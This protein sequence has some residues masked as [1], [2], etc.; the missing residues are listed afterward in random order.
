M[1]T[2]ETQSVD[3]PDG[4]DL[5]LFGRATK[6]ISAVLVGEIEEADIILLGEERATPAQEIKSLKA[7]HHQL[8]RLLAEGTEPGQAAVIAGYTLS[9]V[10]VLQA[11]HAFNELVIFYRNQVT[12]VYLDTH[13]RFNHVAN[14]ALGM[15]EDRMEETPET[16][17]INQL[18]EVAKMGA[19]RTG[20]GPSATQ[21]VNVNVGFAAKLEE[22]RKRAQAAQPFLELQAEQS[23][24]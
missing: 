18:I 15:I 8:A 24:E 3:A 17:S 11:D 7:R 23:S 14:N 4:V 20:H 9:R 21:N 6:P 22:A 13:K 12:D 1:P 10:S 2:T 5:R 19:D 16:F